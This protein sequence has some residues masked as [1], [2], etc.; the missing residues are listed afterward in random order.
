[1]KKLRAIKH[2]EAVLS[3]LRSYNYF[4]RLLYPPCAWFSRFLFSDRFSNRI[5]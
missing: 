3:T 2:S 1:V 4:S 5:I